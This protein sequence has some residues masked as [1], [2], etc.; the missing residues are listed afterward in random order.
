MTTVVATKVAKATKSVQRCLDELAEMEAFN[1]KPEKIGS[2]SLGDVVRQGDVYIMSIPNLPTGQVSEN[3]QLAEGDTQ[4][5]RH[6]LT[7][8]VNIVDKVTSIVKN[9][10]GVAIN[11]AL[12]GPAFECVSDVTETHPEHAH[13]VLPAGTCWQVVYQVAFAEEIRRVRD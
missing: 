6:I 1:N 13:K 4:G 9:H 3:R 2:P 11:A 10:D 12:V 5:S 7:G 8:K